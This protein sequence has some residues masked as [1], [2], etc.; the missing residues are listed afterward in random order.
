V[1]GL[2]HQL[3]EAGTLVTGGGGES[4]AQRVPGIAFGVEPGV[5]RGLLDQAG[6]RLVGEFCSGDPTGL[7]D[8]AEQRPFGARR[9]A[10]GPVEIRGRDDARAGP[11]GRRVDLPWPFQSVRLA[12]QRR[13]RRPG[14]AL[15]SIDRFGWMQTAVCNSLLVVAGQRPN[16][17]T[18]AG[19]VA[20]VIG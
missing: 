16:A 3:G 1:P 12:L 4:G 7:G 19:L 15:A 18:A 5:Q 13:L 11:R 20:V 9:G 10:G 6:D 17:D 14:V 8:G 2:A